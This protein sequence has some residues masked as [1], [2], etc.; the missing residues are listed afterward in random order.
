MDTKTKSVDVETPRKDSTAPVSTRPRVTHPVTSLRD[1]IDRVFDSFLHEW[2]FSG[3]EFPRWS[4]MLPFRG[5]GRADRDSAFG[6]MP[7]TDVTETD[8][9][10]RIT[11]ELPGLEET[12]IELT[13]TDDTLTL[14][15][16]KKDT[17]EDTDRD[18]HLSERR[19]GEF[20][21]SF[22]LPD[23]VDP[24]KTDAVFTKGILTVTLPKTEEAKVEPKR[25]EVKSG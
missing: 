18:V 2:P 8:A 19:Y 13:L 20:R 5:F 25:V 11:V 7:T 15:G 6:H 22:S 17:Y 23:G 9:E 10:Y 3:T 12:D 24:T 1:E 16:E 21:R 14:K 4:P